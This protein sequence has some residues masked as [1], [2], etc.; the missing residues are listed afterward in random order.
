MRFGHG[1]RLSMTRTA[2]DR[3][4]ALQLVR[5]M[6]RIRQQ[7]EPLLG[8]GGGLKLWRFRENRDQRF[9]RLN[10]A[11]GTHCS[12]LVKRYKWL[13]NEIHTRVPAGSGSSREQYFRAWWR[14]VSN[15]LPGLHTA[16][17]FSACLWRAVAAA[18]GLQQEDPGFSS[19]IGLKP[20]FMLRQFVDE[21]PDTEAAGS[22]RVLAYSPLTASTVLAAASASELA[23][24]VYQACL[25]L[26]ATVQ[27]FE[28]SLT[29]MT[30][31][32]IAVAGLND[33]A[34]IARQYSAWLFQ[35]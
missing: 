17:G 29:I 12:V 13:M 2:T 31:G 27:R 6:I 30:D 9:E 19:V 26:H 20:K 23:E 32:A 15:D 21:M 18:A 34:K 1:E 16:D 24:I 28:P 25:S 22:L 4:P 33:P 7:L 14:L 35:S 3:T 10:T 5:E 11:W 8:K